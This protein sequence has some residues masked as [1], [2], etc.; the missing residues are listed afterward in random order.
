MRPLLVLLLAL[1]VFAQT[2]NNELAL[3]VGRA[4]LGTYAAT[5]TTLD[6]VSL[7]FNHY[8]TSTVSTRVGLTEFGVKPFNLD[9]GAGRTV[10]MNAISAAVEY[11]WMRDR[12][13]S[14]F[15]GAGAAYVQSEIEQVHSGILSAGPEVAP[16]VSFGADLNFARS[17]A[18]GLDGTY[19]L[20]RPEYE[21]G[22]REDFDPFTVSA[23]VKLRW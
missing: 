18:V 17:F 14:P 15:A 21:G 22:H 4:A 1:P 8:W 20:Y 9:L 6:T 10:D 11:H 23:G 16:L 13:F 7:S 3:S 2:P 19:L 12:R 5:E